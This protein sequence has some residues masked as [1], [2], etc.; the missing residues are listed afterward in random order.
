MNKMNKSNLQKTIKLSYVIVLSLFSYYIFIGAMYD[1]NSMYDIT[2]KF[3]TKN[4]TKHWYQLCLTEKINS[5][6]VKGRY[7]DFRVNGKLVVAKNEGIDG[8]IARSQYNKERKKTELKLVYF[9]NRN[10]ASQYA[11]SPAKKIV[12]ALFFIS[13][14]IIWYSR[15]YSIPLVNGIMKMF[16]KGWKKL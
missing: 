6:C 3:L 11:D 1:K 12:W 5:K 10:T 9:N 8:Y 7:N 13:L 16:N 14:P 4:F 15:R 2:H